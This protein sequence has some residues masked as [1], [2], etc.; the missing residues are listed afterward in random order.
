MTNL[1]VMGQVV[2]D[3]SGGPTRLWVPAVEKLR[4]AK[5]WDGDMVAWIKAGIRV[6]I[7][8]TKTVCTCFSLQKYSSFSVVIFMLL[9]YVAK[10]LILVWRIYDATSPM[11]I[12][13][14]SENKEWKL[15]K[16]WV[17][18]RVIGH[19][20]KSDQHVKLGFLLEEPS[21]RCWGIAAA[22]TA[23]WNRLINRRRV[24]PHDMVGVLHDWGCF[25]LYTSYNH[26]IIGKL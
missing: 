9:V 16:C 7:L 20:S 17:N 2:L 1:S 21:C 10:E 26:I 4:G 6:L 15:E 22:L 14:Y 3:G 25:C 13:S 24:P 8:D 23:T 19:G 11:I 18:G 12:N 5:E